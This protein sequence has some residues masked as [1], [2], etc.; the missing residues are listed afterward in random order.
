[1]WSA[2]V[3]GSGSE[4]RTTGQKVVAAVLTWTIFAGLTAVALARA[5]HVAR[6]DWAAP[7]ASPPDVARMWPQLDLAGLSASDPLVHDRRPEHER[8]DRQLRNAGRWLI[9][10]G[11]LWYALGRVV[12]LTSA[13]SDA[14]GWWW[15]G[16]VTLLLLGACVWSVR[17]LR[18]RAIGRTGALAIDSDALVSLSSL[19]FCVQRPAG[20]WVWSMAPQAFLAPQ[21]LSGP[22]HY[23][24]AASGLFRD[25]QILVAAQHARVPGRTGITTARTRTACVLRHPGMRLP[26]VTVAGR[27]AVPPAQR[28]SSIS[29]ELEEFNRSIWAWGPDQR[30]VYDVMHG[31]AMSHVL[32]L[33]PDGATVITGGESIAVL[34]DE[35]VSPHSLRQLVLV[36]VGLRE[37]VPSSL[38]VG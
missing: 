8:R 24:W 10:L 2:I 5:L 11:S 22:V 19:G 7:P 12:Q 4:D 37:L 14:P 29:L 16:T 27:E 17:R 1:M 34:T 6:V 32:R 30:G 31:R 3:L 36:V 25:S 26:L 35:P 15:A 13:Q 21:A 9:A 33:L 38:A 23:P 20:A 28:P 18:W